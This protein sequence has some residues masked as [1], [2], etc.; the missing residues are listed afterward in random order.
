MKCPNCEDVELT[1]ATRKVTFED[2]DDSEITVEVTAEW[3][4]E[5]NY[6][7]GAY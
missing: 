7:H 5:C 2:F 1:S 4:K 6:Y 3:C